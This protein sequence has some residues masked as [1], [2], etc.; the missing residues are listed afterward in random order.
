MVVGMIPHRVA[1]LHHPLDKIRAG[2][3]IIAH[4]K[5]GGLGVVL[6]QRVEN[7]RR[8]AVFIPR[9]KGE[10]DGFFRGIPEI[11]GIVLPEILRRGVADGGS[12]S[13][14]KLS[15]QLVLAAF[16][17]A[18]ALCRGIRAAP[19]GTRASARQQHRAAARCL[20]RMIRYINTLPFRP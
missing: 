12:P 6:F 14:W 19:T 17:A 10:V 15:P 13:F 1:F 16:P 11:V 4:H 9:I 5:K 3:D 7:R 2:F 8:I 20:R 18:A